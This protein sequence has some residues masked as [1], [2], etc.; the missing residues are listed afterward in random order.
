MTTTT[1]TTMNFLLRVLLIV[2]PLGLNLKGSTFAAEHLASPARSLGVDWDDWINSK[3]DKFD[4][5]AIDDDRN[6]YLVSSKKY[7]DSTRRVFFEVMQFTS[8]REMEGRSYYS[9]DGGG[10]DSSSDANHVLSQNQAYGMLGAAFVLGSWKTHSGRGSSSEEDEH[11]NNAVSDFEGFFN[12]WRKMCFN[13][14]PEGGCQADGKW[15]TDPIT[16]K[17]VICLPGWKQNAD[18]S[19]E[20]GSNSS[21]DADADAILAMIIAIKAFEGKQKPSWY[22]E[23]RQWADAS[24][25]AFLYFNT[26]STD[27]TS[28][29]NKRI[30]KVGSCWGGFGKQG[31][32]PTHYSPGHFKV[33]QDFHVSFPETERS[34]ALPQ[35]MSTTNIKEEWDQLIETSYDVLFAVQCPIEGM[36]PNWAMV[37]IVGDGIEN[38]GDPFSGSGTPQWQYGTEAAR[39]TWRVALDAALFP[40]ETKNPARVYL[41]PLLNTLRNGFDGNLADESYFSSETF[42]TCFDRRNG[43]QITPFSGGWNTNA[44]ILAP[45]LSSLVVPIEGLSKDEQEQMLDV[46]VDALLHIATKNSNEGLYARTWRVLA[47]MTLTGVVESVGKLLAITPSTTTTGGKNFPVTPMSVETS[48]ESSTNND[49]C[50]GWTDT[51]DLNNTFCD[52]SC[53][54]CSG[55][56]GGTWFV[57][58]EKVEGC[59][60]DLTVELPGTPEAA[61]EEGCCTFGGWTSCPHWTQRS[62]DKCQQTFNTC[63][64]VCQGLWIGGSKDYE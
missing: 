41:K 53:I 26:I 60:E 36:V 44:A 3:V 1:T 33:M 38:T 17:A 39:T 57:N 34:D 5:I 51:C 64:K 50:C 15:C 61:N 55:R 56:C 48:G 8:K 19:A 63:E 42:N 24:C 20:I 59:R 6:N 32:S 2:V 62:V 21:P 37:D 11:W 16:K 54:N 45:T 7:L 52:E 58:G 25:S 46:I 23:L 27:N 18:L 40:E 14:D 30:M 43:Q 31:N 47:V 29:K 35:S 9:L 4:H 28:G 10:G 49:G 12:G 13:S 22:R